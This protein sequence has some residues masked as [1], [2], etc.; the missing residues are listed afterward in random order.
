MLSI[1]CDFYRVIYDQYTAYVELL[2]HEN[3]RNQKSHL[4]QYKEE[5]VWS[6]LMVVTGAI[7][8]TI[9]LFIYH[10]FLHFI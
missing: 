7:E 6:I 4:G 10:Y 5:L 9:T 1:I 3:T 2:Y 8:M